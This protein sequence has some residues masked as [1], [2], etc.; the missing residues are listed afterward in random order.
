MGTNS[1]LGGGGFHHVALK[2]RDW[3]A[4]LAFYCGVLGFAEKWTWTMKTGRRAALLDVGDGNYL[5]L[6]EDPDFA[7]SAEGPL[8]HVA[9]RSTRVDAVAAL[10]RAAGARVTYEPADV[11]L[12]ST[13]GRPPLTAR[14]AFF[15]GPNGEIWEL[16][17][18]QLT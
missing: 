15:A 17:D 8:R 3:D 1:I 16:F 11:A 10:A 7:A 2:A 13:G 5:E 6:F 4:S 14:I 12:A 18:N 9:L